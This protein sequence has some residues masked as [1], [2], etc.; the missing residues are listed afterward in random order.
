MLLVDATYIHN[1]GGRI[2][3]NYLIMKLLESEKD[4]FFLLDNRCEPDFNFIPSQH[5]LHL[6]T[7]LWSRYQ[8][9]A[10]RKNH[11]SK[12][13]CLGNLPPPVKL[14]AEVY[15]Y[16]QNLI[17]L[18][19]SNY[20][21]INKSILWLKSWYINFY[22]RNTD[23]VIVQ[24]DYVKDSFCKKYQYSEI[25]CFTIPFF[26]NFV[27]KKPT[28][29]RR[30]E[31]FLFVSD[32]NTHKNHENL[33]KA[34]EMVNQENPNLELHLTV[35]QIYPKLLKIIEQYQAKGLNIINHGR[36]S[37]TDLNELYQ[38][39]EYI[40]YP[41]FTESF[42]L[43]L[44]EGVLAG[45]K[46]IVSNRPYAFAVVEPFE[47]FNPLD[48]KDIANKIVESYLSKEPF[49]TTNIKVEDD[50]KMLINLLTSVVDKTKQP[51]NAID[52]HSETAIKFDEK[53]NQSLQFQER[54]RV[55]TALFE[56]Y[57]QPGMS[58]LDAG[59]GSGIFSIYL[60]EKE[61]KVVGIDGSGKMIE[62]C[63]HNKVGK[64]L[65]IAFKHEELPLKQPQ[66]YVQ[67]DVILCSSVLEYIIDYEEVIEQFMQI[68]NPAGFL[69]VSMPNKDSW[70]RKV[71]KYIF[72]IT[73]R[74]SYYAYIKHIVSEKDFT[75]NLNQY[76]FEL[77]KIVYYPNTNWFS[78]LMKCIGLNEKYTNTM[79]VG[80]YKKIR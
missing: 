37:Q 77:Q 64:G 42:G 38:A 7:N 21:R 41:S 49:N 58:V 70:Y 50:I 29:I 43:G 60:A 10:S 4:V 44:I 31:H 13:I 17:Y 5:R 18:D 57:I 32:G 26:E 40:V 68:L 30:K 62:L 6:K 48:F 63:N 59:C 52:F 3:L 74:P 19:Y 71:E 55:W 54:F 46:P 22:L 34:W 23:Y 67:K 65:S 15:T 39:S 66:N 16:F 75:K 56:Q 24:T 80:V 28:K 35:S 72:K 45:C 51:K 78:K 27:E 79:F 20:Y 14:K 36:V 69:I 47:V 73:K 33:L 8:F 2:L 9:Y 25:Q 12:V 76:G 1:G 61:C 53:Y 11:F